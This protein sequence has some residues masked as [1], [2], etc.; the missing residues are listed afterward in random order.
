ML[1]R[2]G[3]TWLEATWGVSLQV[4]TGA[5]LLHW[6][7]WRQTVVWMVASTWLALVVRVYARTKGRSL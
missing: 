4:S 7:G 5:L 1:Q 6:W 3:M 2:E